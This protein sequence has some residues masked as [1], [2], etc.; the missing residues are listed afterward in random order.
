MVNVLSQGD[1]ELVT[2]DYG[3]LLQ[4]IIQILKNKNIFK[5]SEKG[6]RLLMEI[7]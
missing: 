4:K 5:F 3:D 1:N 2:L 6:D 7:D